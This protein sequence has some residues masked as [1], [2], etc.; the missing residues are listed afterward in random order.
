M[1]YRTHNLGELRKN[2]IGEK[3]ILSGWVAT[4]KRPWRIYFRRPER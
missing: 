1:I 3:V 4:K 2:N